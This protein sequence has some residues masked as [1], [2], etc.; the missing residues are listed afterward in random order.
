MSLYRAI[1]Y[2]KLGYRVRPGSECWSRKNGY[3][4]KANFIK[5]VMVIPGILYE[6]DVEIEV[7]R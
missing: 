2:L 4:D 3:F 7:K 1:E 6:E 5:Y